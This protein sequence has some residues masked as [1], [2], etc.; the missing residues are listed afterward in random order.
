MAP[1]EY[2]A[3]LS[4]DEESYIRLM[5]AGRPDAFIKALSAY[6]SRQ[7]ERLH[8][9]SVPA[10][11]LERYLSPRFA[12]ESS[13]YAIVPELRIPEPHSLSG[14]YLLSTGDIS[15]QLVEV[16]RKS[17]LDYWTAHLQGELCPRASLDE[18][19]LVLLD[20]I[21]AVPGTR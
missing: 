9:L 17:P 11:D 12:E 1:A 2:L 18:H 4:G 6:A 5:A 7:L 10:A 14:R 20:E 3:Q 8:H 21:F 19:L 13:G 15:A 16:E